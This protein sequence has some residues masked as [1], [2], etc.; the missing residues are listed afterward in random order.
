[1]IIT[2]GHDGTGT[3]VRFGD[4]PRIPLSDLTPEQLRRVKVAGLLDKP[5]AKGAKR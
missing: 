1:M 2:L 5:K 4:G 3:W